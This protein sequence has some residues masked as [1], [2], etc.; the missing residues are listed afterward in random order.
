MGRK[1]RS[2]L[3][4]ISTWRACCPAV[5]LLLLSWPNDA[6]ADISF[7][8]LFNNPTCRLYEYETPVYPYKML[9]EK[10]RPD[11]VNP[12]THK[13]KDIYCRPTDFP[14]DT[15]SRSPVF[16]RI[17]SLLTTDLVSLDAVFFLF[18]SN[19]LSDAFCAAYGRKPFKMRLVLQK[20]IKSE[21]V[22][23]LESCFGKDL[24]LSEIGCD[25]VHGD[26]SCRGDLI[27]TMHAKLIRVVYGDGHSS[28]VIGSGNANYSLYGTRDVWVYVTVPVTDQSNKIYTQINCQVDV[29]LRTEWQAGV[30]KDDISRSY[31][32]CLGGPARF[33]ESETFTS[34]LLPVSG[35]P[36]PLLDE[37]IPKLAGSSDSIFLT[38]QDLGGRKLPGILQQFAQRGGSLRILLDDDWFYVRFLGETFGMADF[39]FATG[40]LQ[41]LS[42]S[43][44]N[45]VQIRY[46]ETDNTAN[47][48]TSLHHKFMV[49]QGKAAPIVLF[50]SPNLKDGAFVSNI[51]TLWVTSRPEITEPFLTEVDRLWNS[52]LPEG[53]MP[54]VDSN[55]FKG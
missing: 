22:A 1:A 51:E 26:S 19:E 6:R 4:L 55:L 35:A 34:Y 5:L 9:L 48:Q 24:T 3:G 20:G 27:S 44:P 18:E 28:F 52:A 47:F 33:D 8:V 31:S 38:S 17:Q 23:R 42:A 7:E 37:L 30:K 14:T 40:W 36:H 11:Q 53:S 16:L 54:F 46:L 43:F 15:K 32:G 41:S 2:V 21:A 12:I 49:F 13:T 45:N 50:G 39:D 10:L 29:L 25:W